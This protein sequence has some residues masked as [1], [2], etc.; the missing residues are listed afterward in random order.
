[1]STHNPAL[2]AAGGPSGN[3]N[4][5][6]AFMVAIAVLAAMY[7]GWAFSRCSLNSLEKR[8]SSPISRKSCSAAW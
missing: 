7:A 5:V 2:D 6:S 1:M 4:K 3:Y 8:F